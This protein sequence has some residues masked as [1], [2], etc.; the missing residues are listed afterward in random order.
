MPWTKRRVTLG[1]DVA[2]QRRQ[3]PLHV[4]PSAGAAPS[5]AVAWQPGAPPWLMARKKAA[6]PRLS[7]GGC[8]GCSASPDCLHSARCMHAYLH[9]ADYIYMLLSCQFLHLRWPP[10][11]SEKPRGIKDSSRSREKRVT[12][13]AAVGFHGV[14]SLSLV[15]TLPWVQVVYQAMSEV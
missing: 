1:S 4:P 11:N 10:N 13:F 5:C 9:V 14:K 3:Q 12:G 2:V 8:S 6:R 7:R 15:G